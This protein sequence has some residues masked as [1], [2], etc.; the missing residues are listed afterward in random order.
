MDA[1][2]AI[3]KS[4]PL[5][6]VGFQPYIYTFYIFFSIIDDERSKIK[7][8]NVLSSIS[9]I[10]YLTLTKKPTQGLDKFLETS[11]LVQINKV[12]FIIGNVIKL[13]LNV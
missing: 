4:P 7:S 2:T 3:E 9:N 10:F 5:S 13:H 12:F 11:E 1:P 8:A 6:K